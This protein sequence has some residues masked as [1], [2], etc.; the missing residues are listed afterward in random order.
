MK[1]NLL[2]T[3]VLIQPSDVMTPGSHLYIQVFLVIIVLQYE[4]S[5]YEERK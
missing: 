1:P 4:Q 5:F 2:N 3:V